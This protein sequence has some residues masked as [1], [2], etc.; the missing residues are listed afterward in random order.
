ME[1]IGNTKTHREEVER[2][3]GSTRCWHEARRWRETTSVTNMTLED[4]FRCGVYL[5]IGTEERRLDPCSDRE[6]HK[7]QLAFLNTQEHL[8]GVAPTTV[9]WALLHQA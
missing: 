1:S 3:H 9:V 2:L 7:V 8:P 4:G 6:T 5:D